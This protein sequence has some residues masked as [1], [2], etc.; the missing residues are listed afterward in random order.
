MRHLRIA[1]IL[2]GGLLFASALFPAA[3]SS[4]GEDVDGFLQALYEHNYFDTALEYIDQIKTSPLV[5]KDTKAAILFLHA[6][7]EQYQAVA[8]PDARMLEKETKYRKA[9]G[10]FLAFDKAQPKHPRAIQSLLEV[11]DIYRTIAKKRLEAGGAGADGKEASGAGAGVVQA[12][13]YFKNSETTYKVIVA[14]LKGSLRSL[15]KNPP[16]PDEVDIAALRSQINA[17]LVSAEFQLAEVALDAAGTHKPGTGPHKK[18]LGVA[19]ER[20][21]SFFDAHSDLIIGMTAIVRAGQCYRDMGNDD[22]ALSCFESILDDPDLAKLEALRDIRLETISESIKL[23]TKQIDKAKKYS[24]ALSVFERAFR[25]SALQGKKE[26]L[27]KHPR[28]LTVLFQRAE[29]AATMAK[30]IRLIKLKDIEKR[31]KE[32]FQYAVETFK[33][34]AETEGRHQADAVAALGGAWSKKESLAEAYKKAFGKE[35]PKIV[36]KIDNLNDFDDFLKASRKI[37]ARWTSTLAAIAQADKAGKAKLTEKSL[38]QLEMIDGLLR[39]ALDLATDETKLSD[40]SDIYSRMAIVYWYQNRYAEAAV[41]GEHLARRYPEAMSARTSADIAIKSWSKMYSESKEAGRDVD[42]ERTKI[43]SLGTYVSDRWPDSE[44]AADALYRLIAFAL[45]KKDLDAGL[46]LLARMPQN[47]PHYPSTQLIL[48]RK[49]WRQHQKLRYEFQQKY[50]AFQKNKQKLDENAILKT[51]TQLAALQAKLPVLVAKVEPMLAEGLAGNGGASS[52]SPKLTY[53]ALFLAE[54]YV[55]TDRPK[56][57]VDWLENKSI[58]PLTL[59]DQ[60]QAII[61]GQRGM[62]TSVYRTALKSYVKLL[63]SLQGE[64]FTAAKKRFEDLMVKFEGSAGIKNKAVITGTYRLLGQIIEK[65]IQKNI[66]AGNDAAVARL[67][68]IFKLILVKISKDPNASYGVLVGVAKS[69]NGLGTTSQQLANNSELGEAARAEH[70][71]KSKESFRDAATA[72]NGL[73]KRRKKLKLSDA[74]VVAL[75]IALA[76]CQLGM[77]DFENSIK[78]ITKALK[79][80]P[81]YISAQRIAAMALQQNGNYAEAIKG[82]GERQRKSNRRLIWGWRK[83]AERVEGKPN[84][85]DI[86]FEANLA[87]IDCLTSKGKAGAAKSL[88]AAK[89]TLRNFKIMFPEMGGKKWKPKFDA[90]DKRLN[91]KKNNR[92]MRTRE[93]RNNSKPRIIR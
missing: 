93:E 21:E 76:E 69:L 75:T 18:K 58:G 40:L 12:R 48:G 19:A 85:E 35:L 55:L 36:E 29:L 5:D 81:N 14:R 32:L 3:S 10:S 68:E 88:S 46:A 86:F 28:S 49:L 63:A 47:T 53:D 39:Q 1:P 80:Q 9:I 6:R 87:V 17:Q 22:F 73:L 33:M 43:E 15:I 31:Y 83:L 89:K 64:E 50:A 79:K 66:K 8:I 16:N 34:V 90:A 67:T 38:E 65:D 4:A 45:E 41:I 42:F 23:W 71:K 44:Q 27:R 56:L 82:K 77:D 13:K 52:P 30:R 92:P 59:L 78:T 20:Y 70:S 51:Q 25:I 91:P 7:T 24:Q 57:A 37:Y 2:W 61:A 11:G 72:Y 84:Y 74:S 54:L 60:K 26:E 62:D